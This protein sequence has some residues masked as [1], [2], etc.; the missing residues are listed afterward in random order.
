MNQKDIKTVGTD[1][2]VLRLDDPTMLTRVEHYPDELREPVL[3]LAAY[4]RNECNRDL[5]LLAGHA[6]KLGI[7]FDKT[8][9]SKVLRG[10]WNRSAGGEATGPIVSLK[11]LTDSLA[12]LRRDVALREMAG[13][14]PFV[15]TPTAQ[16]IFHFVDKKRAPDRI[17]KFG[18]IVGHTGTQ[19]SATLS[20]YCRRNNHGT[21]VKIEA[22]ATPSQTQFI[23]DLAEHYGC[24]RQATW[25]RKRNTIRESVNERRCIMVENVQRLYS[26]KEAEN[27][28]VFNYLQKLQDDTGC[29]IILT[30]TPVFVSK[31]RN[32][33]AE[34]Y[35]EQFIGR[36]GGTRDIL[37]LEAYPSAEDVEAIATS[38][39]IDWLDK[40]TSWRVPNL[41][42]DAPDVTGPALEY[43]TSI[44]REE[45]R[46]RI[47]FEC[48]QDAKVLAGKK[49][50]TLAHVRTARDED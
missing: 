21:C 50:I 47:L 25:D 46:V 34:G 15:M 10:L 31:L 5:D 13:K 48:L 23:T 49:P 7:S 18:M 4:V 6:G 1:D 22:P 36:A 35:F 14:V 45:G 38:F 26:E 9:W 20:E 11:K 37:T 42:A 41:P 19:K 44:A 24:S 39:G 43:L 40:P 8:T 33:I 32:R 16:G 2:R 3:W 17:N 12:S 30:L 27:Q 29:T 28:R